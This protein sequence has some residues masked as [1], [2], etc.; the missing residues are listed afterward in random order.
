MT[1]TIERISSTGEWR[2][3][4]LMVEGVEYAPLLPDAQMIVDAV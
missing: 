1:S 3:K 4:I 2:G